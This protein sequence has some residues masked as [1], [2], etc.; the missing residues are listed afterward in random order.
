MESTARPAASGCGVS[1]SAHKY[2]QYAPDFCCLEH[3]LAIEV[4]GGQHFEQAAICY[5][6]ARTRF[7]GERGVRVLRFTSLEVLNETEAVVE[8]I[9]LAVGTPSPSPYPSPSGE[10]G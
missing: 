6:E 7:L 1:A 8:A 10:R 2:R 5:D 9:W 4:D 3:R